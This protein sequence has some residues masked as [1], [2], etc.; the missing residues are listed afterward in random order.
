MSETEFDNN[1]NNK[2]ET[3]REKLL[4][5]A[6]VLFCEKGFDGTSVRDLTT[7]ARCNVAAVNYHFGGKD[8]LYVEMF[9]RQMQRMFQRHGE[10]IDSIAENPE[11][12]LEDLIRGAI[13]E[14]LKA[15]E[16]KE[17]SAAV[18][19]LLVREV[20]NQHV[21]RDEVIGDLKK[22]FL[23]VFCKA[24][25]RLCP[26]LDIEPATLCMFSLDALIVHPI[27]FYEIYME[28][29]PQINA[30]RVI[31]HIVNFASAGIRTYCKE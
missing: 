28:T 7:A 12:T 24:I 30:D 29:I 27:L 19:K 20:L 4:D 31:E 6:E 22:E 15:I 26:G 10:L 13:T 2:S 21:R 18:M 23:L 14:P 8:N 11:A 3:V 16:N 9:R 25:M 5:V 1:I 17:K